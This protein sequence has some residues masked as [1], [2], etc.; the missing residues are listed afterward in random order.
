MKA[1]WAV[2]KSDS[3]EKAR[4]ANIVSRTDLSKTNETS[5]LVKQDEQVTFSSK[6]FFGTPLPLIPDVRKSEVGEGVVGQLLE[7]LGVSHIK[8]FKRVVTLKR[9]PNKRINRYLI[10]QYTRLIKSIDGT[11]VKGNSDF[12]AHVIWAYNIYKITS[13][14]LT[15]EEKAKLLN[16]KVKK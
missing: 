5:S 3:E 13:P 11:L 10:Y 1:L 15:Q 6:G 9:G 2:Y 7:A 4:E 16:I 12:P 8:K 14:E